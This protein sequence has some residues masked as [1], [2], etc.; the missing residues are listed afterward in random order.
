M[1]LGNQNGCGNDEILRE[2]CCGR[3]RH[4]AR[5]NGEVERAG[6]LQAAGGRGEAESEREGG[7]GE[8]VLHQRDIRVTSA[9]LPE[10]TSD[11]PQPRRGIIAVL[12]PGLH[13]WFGS[14]FDGFFVETSFQTCDSVSDAFGRGT[15]GDFFRGKR[16]VNAEAS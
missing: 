13:S 12:L 15:A 3:G 5:K 2:D 1:L 8:G 6:F 4:V 16:S 9:S 11:P 14:C 10:G 7:F